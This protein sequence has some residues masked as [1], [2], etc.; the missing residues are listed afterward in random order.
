[1]ED[2]IRKVLERKKAK[3]FSPLTASQCGYEGIQDYCRR[4]RV[5]DFYFKENVEGFEPLQEIFLRGLFIEMAYIEILRQE[6]KDVK[7]GIT[8][9]YKGLKV[10]PDVIVNDKIVEIKSVS[11]IPEKVKE[12]HRI[13]A[14]IQM[15]AFNL[16]SEIHYVKVDSEG[17]DVKV[18]D[19]EPLKQE[20]IAKILDENKKVIETI[21]KNEYPEIPQDKMPNKSPCSFCP[22]Y[23]MCW[24]E[25]E[26]I[27]LTLSVEIDKYYELRQR[28]KELNREVKD[29]KEELEKWE[30]AF[31]KES[32]R[33][34][35]GKYLLSV[36]VI[37]GGQEIKYIKPDIIRYHIKKEEGK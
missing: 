36:S 20:E 30:K 14:G 21:K 9:Y 33:Y 27:N 29:L 18:Y 31:P 25:Q 15:L 24:Q 22:H 19:V 4:K 23:H 35:I 6:Y 37:K 17:I 7:T 2:I 28:Y 11:R 3:V 32:G 1:M 12:L 16:K 26:Q 8:G 5:F 10:D 34:L 13:Q